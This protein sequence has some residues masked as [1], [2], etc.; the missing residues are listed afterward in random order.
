MSFSIE[1][2]SAISR[3]T[4]RARD[5]GANEVGSVDVLLALLGAQDS[6]AGRAIAT[7]TPDWPIADLIASSCGSGVTRRV[8]SGLVPLSHGMQTVMRDLRTNLGLVQST[9][10][11]LAIAQMDSAA[12]LLRRWGV[13]LP[14]LRSACRGEHAGGAEQPA[15]ASSAQSAGQTVHTRPIS[16][17]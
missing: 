8:S 10:L 4:E 11:L 5:R 2:A 16:V 14:D 7:V 9:D 6:L 12:E 17:R 13:D 3:A 1:V 15:S